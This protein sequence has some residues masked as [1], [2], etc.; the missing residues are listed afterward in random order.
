VFKVTITN[1]TEAL[2]TGLRWRDVAFNGEWQSLSDLAAG[3]SVEVTGSFGP[4]QQMHL[5]GIILTVAA[6]SDQTAER[7]ASRYVNL[8]EAPTEEQTE[9][10]GQSQQLVLAPV[11]YATLSTLWLRVERVR[12]TVPDVHLAHNIPDLT[13]TLPDGTVVKCE[14]LKHYDE[15]GGL[16]R[17]GYAISEVF[18]ERPWTLTQY[19]QRGVVDCHP[20][21]YRNDPWVTERRL[22]W[23][24]IG[25]GAGGAPDLG[26]ESA[27]V[28]EQP[29]VPLWTWGHRVS[30]Y[31][32]E[33][34]E[35]GFLDFFD[36][37][38]GIKSFG[39]PKTDA[40]YDNHPLANLTIPGTDTAMIRQY[41]Q[42]AGLEYYPYDDLQP[43]K[44]ALLGDLLRDRN[45]PY[46]SYL[47]FKSFK[48][49]FPLRVGE[50]LQPERAIFP[51]DFILPGVVS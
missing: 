35:V 36:A 6:D 14:F 41:F 15:T 42:A 39:Y 28:S 22:A 43:V 11:P 26:V 25:G 18:E 12:Y 51:A 16:T 40:R 7:P 10:S 24:Y 32:I 37:L 50:V 38:G 21:V 47:A 48:S 31:A 5:P 13:L 9:Q 8:T 44:P 49:V 46:L 4:V 27:L 34:T 45:F 29:G 23:D 17:W 20:N 30:N 19:Y 33:G 2:M 3:A 1:N